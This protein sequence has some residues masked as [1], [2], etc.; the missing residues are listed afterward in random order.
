MS[1]VYIAILNRCKYCIEQFTFSVQIQLWWA[2]LSYAM[3][4]RLEF[5]T[6]K[7]CERITQQEDRIAFGLK[8]LGCNMLCIMYKP[9]HTNNWCRINR[10]F[11]IFVIQTDVTANYRSIEN[12]TSFCHTVNRFFHLPENFRLLRTSKVQV[13]SNRK[14]FG[15][16]A[17]DV[18]RCFT[19][20]NASTHF[21]VQIY[22]TSVTICRHRKSFACSANGNNSGI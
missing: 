1:R 10:A 22:E 14:R 12:A 5:T 20:R 2:S 7:L 9:N 4:N 13:I 6:S 15:T 17:N 3:N 11:C 8:A 19:N 21:R 18:T 16:G